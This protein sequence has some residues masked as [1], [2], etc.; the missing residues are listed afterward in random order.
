MG[1]VEQLFFLEKV[2]AVSVVNEGIVNSDCFLGEFLGDL[3]DVRGRPAKSPSTEKSGTFADVEWADE[4]IVSADASGR[5]TK[6]PSTERSDTFG[7]DEWIDK[8]I[9]SAVSTNPCVRSFAFSEGLSWRI[10]I[11]FYKKRYN[12]CNFINRLIVKF[13]L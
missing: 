1:N 5:S 10:W 8:G 7:G 4:V 9:V 3:S 12:W 13:P 11:E 2:T 6:S